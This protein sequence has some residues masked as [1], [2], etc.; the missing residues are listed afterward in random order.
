M[1]FLRNLLGRNRAAGAGGAAGADRSV[2][3]G[4]RRL[5]LGLKPE[6]LG[7]APTAELPNV[8]A[9]IFD[10]AMAHGSVT[11]ACVVDGS[12]SLY[13]S[14]GGGIIGAGGHAVA[15]DANRHLLR[16]I[17]RVLDAFEPTTDAPVPS[18]GRSAL[19]ACT[20]GGL[21]RIEGAEPDV[22]GEGFPPRAAFVAAQ[23]VIT[24]IREVD[25]ARDRG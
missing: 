25:A 17:E 1:G 8:Y 18:A 21:R 14:S 22:Y 6:S 7:L 4:M 10:V 2:Y 19:V 11:V 15:V 12:T 3:G 20:Y 5:V 24:A 13:T 16:S 9:A 23:G